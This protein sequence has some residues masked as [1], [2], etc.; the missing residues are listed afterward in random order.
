MW[1]SCSMPPTAWATTRSAV[2]CGTKPSRRRARKEVAGDESLK[3]LIE[4]GVTFWRGEDL[5]S[6]VED[7]PRPLAEL[8]GERRQFAPRRIEHHA[9]SSIATKRV[10]PSGNTGASRS[11]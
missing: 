11:V 4:A 5:V 8:V 7:L 2:W 9:A 6:K 1:P 10:S 3:V